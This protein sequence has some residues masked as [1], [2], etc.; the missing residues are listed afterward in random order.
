MWVFNVLLYLMF[1][2]NPTVYDAMK[3]SGAP[4]YAFVAS[5]ADAEHP[6]GIDP[7]PC[8]YDPTN[9]NGAAGLRKARRA[10]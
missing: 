9:A 10:Q 7:P 3:A 6:A 8:F 5:L 2:F 1:V 4:C